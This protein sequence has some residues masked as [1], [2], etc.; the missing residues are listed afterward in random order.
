MATVSDI[1]VAWGRTQD[2]SLAPGIPLE[3]LPFPAAVVHRG[4]II[5]AV[6]PEWLD[7]FPAS[8]PDCHTGSW[9]ETVHPGSPNLRVELM[10]GIQAALDGRRFLQEF[11]ED[12]RCRIHIS[13]CATGALI[14]YQQISCDDDPAAEQKRQAHR[15]E[16]LGRLLAGVAHDFANL[17]T[18]ISGYSDILLN[19]LSEHD[20][21]RNEADEIRKAAGRGARLT[22]Q[23][24]GFTRGHASQPKALDLNALV[25]GVQRMLRPLIGEDVEMRAT[26]AP[27]LDKVVID[28]GE[29]E[30]VIMNLI[31]NARDAVSP[32][33]SILL[34]TFNQNF[35]EQTAREHSVVPGPYVVFAIHDDGHG[36][37]GE[38]MQK[39]FDPLF[40]T[41][42]E[43][44]GAGLGL[45]NVQQIVRNSG[46]DVWAVSTPGA[47]ATFTV[48]LPRA[49]QAPEGGES[50]S[51]AQGASAGETILLVEDESSVRRL[52]MHVLR[53]RGY[54][55][56]EAP[57]GDQALEIFCSHPGE[58]HLVLTDMVMPKMG[59]RE[60]SRQLHQIDPDIKVIFMSGYTDDVLIRT[61]SLNP[62]MTFLQKPLRPDV[63]SAKVREALDSPKR[64]FDL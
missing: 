33:G 26:L 56:L 39:L 38:A 61:G 42:P 31:L 28:P 2:Y 64:P 29:M 40:T 17:L 4:E 22:S 21:L 6:N 45:S 53:N 54:R 37:A 30:R 25:T 51:A 48:C 27:N 58:I 13:P 8:V 19:R 62:G 5:A 10:A 15:M 47:G 44:K 11:G 16:T 57:D 34:E 23:L 7:A 49:S 60:L 12:R 43:G 50:A 46:G 52:L 24:L 1:R 59:G 9:C 18:L 55:V 20:P 3:S 14:V 41:K 32:G 35:N 63:L 36:I